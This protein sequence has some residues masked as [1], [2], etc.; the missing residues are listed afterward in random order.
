M[1]QQRKKLVLNN[2]MAF[3]DQQL[4]STPVSPLNSQAV[5]SP[6]LQPFS[7]LALVNNTAEHLRPDNN[8]QSDIVPQL[9]HAQS[10]EYNSPLKNLNCSKTVKTRQDDSQKSDNDKITELLTGIIL[11]ILFSS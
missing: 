1:G 7:N 4:T 8:K 5:P 10:L 3:I 6:R 9:L 2:S 11:T